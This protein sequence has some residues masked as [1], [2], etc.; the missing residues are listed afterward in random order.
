LLGSEKSPEWVS[1]STEAVVSDCG[2]DA[3]SLV[4][5]VDRQPEASHVAD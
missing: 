1:V 2:E 3:E 4:V 5:I